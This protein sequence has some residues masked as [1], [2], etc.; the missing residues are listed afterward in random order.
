M[1]RRPAHS[2]ET[3]PSPNAAQRAAPPS[4]V[5]EKKTSLDP[6]TE[7]IRDFVHGLAN[8]LRSQPD[9]YVVAT[10]ADGAKGFNAGDVLTFRHVAITDL[11][12]A[13]I[14]KGDTV[15]FVRRDQAPVQSGQVVVF[16]TDLL[17]TDG[18][19][20]LVCGQVNLAQDGQIQVEVHSV[21][22]TKI[23]VM[24]IDESAVRGPVLVTIRDLDPADLPT[25]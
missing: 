23:A 14:Q 1:F 7:L 25:S 13:G 18:T 12:Q 15:V 24:P 9:A 2:R 16:E 19:R 8:D 4:P 6:G 21:G 17:S 22:E 5:P 3:Y 20:A 10:E 11:P